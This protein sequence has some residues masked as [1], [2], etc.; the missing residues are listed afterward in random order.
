MEGEKVEK[1]TKVKGKGKG[2]QNK[3]KKQPKDAK[4]DAQ[5]TTNNNKAGGGG[6]DFKSSVGNDVSN[7]FHNMLIDTATGKTGISSPLTKL[8]T[9]ATA[10]IDIDVS[11]SIV[12]G[13]VGFLDAEKLKHVPLKHGLSLLRHLNS[14]SP[15]SKL[16]HTALIQ[17]FDDLV[18]VL[19]GWAMT[20]GLGEVRDDVMDTLQSL[21]PQ[22]GSK[23][24]IA[25]N[26]LQCL[27]EDIGVITEFKTEKEDGSAYFT[28]MS[29]PLACLGAISF[30][31]PSSIITQKKADSE[32]GKV[33]VSEGDLVLKALL[34]AR[35]CAETTSTHMDKWRETACSLVKVF[36]DALPVNE[37]LAHYPLFVTLLLGDCLLKGADNGDTLNVNSITNQR[38]QRHIL[39]QHASLFNKLPSHKLEGITL[40]ILKP[41][42]NPS[43]N[44]EL[45]EDMSSVYCVGGMRALTILCLL[46]GHI[47]GSQH[48]ISFWRRGERTY[49]SAAQTSASTL[50]V[51]SS[52]GQSELVTNKQSTK[53]SDDERDVLL[54]TFVGFAGTGA[55]S[56]MFA[57]EI[58]M[59]MASQDDGH[60][61]ELEVAY[62]N[63]AVLQQCFQRH[64]LSLDCS[65]IVLNIRCSAL[66]PTSSSVSTLLPGFV[67]LVISA[68]RHVVQL[69]DT[70]EMKP[71]T[72]I[73][74]EK[75]PQQLA[76]LGLHLV[77]EASEQVSEQ[78]SEELEQGLALV[79]TALSLGTNDVSMDWS[80]LIHVLVRLFSKSSVSSIRLIVTETLG[81]LA[82]RHLITGEH[83]MT[84][85]Q[86]VLRQQ[87]TVKGAHFDTLSMELVGLLSPCLLSQTS[88]KAVRSMGDSHRLQRKLLRWSGGVEH[89]IAVED[90]KKVLQ[91]LCLGS[92]DKESEG[93]FCFAEWCVSRFIAWSEVVDPSHTKAWTLVGAVQR[94]P[95]QA[96]LWMC[97]QAARMVV[98][99]RLKTHFGGPKETFNAIERALRPSSSSS[100]SSSTTA[101]VR[102]SSASVRPANRG[103]RTALSG[104]GLEGQVPRAL[105]QI[106]NTPPPPPASTAAASLPVEASRPPPVARDLLRDR[107]LLVLVDALEKHIYHASNGT[108]RI[109]H[110][111]LS[112][113]EEKNSDKSESDSDLD[114][115]ESARK[116]CERMKSR[117][118]HS[119]SGDSFV[120]PAPSPNCEA[121]FRNNKRVCEDWFARIRSLQMSLAAYSLSAP[122]VVRQAMLRLGDL[123]RRMGAI[124]S[125]SPPQTHKEG[126]TDKV[127]G[128]GN[129]LQKAWNDV[130]SL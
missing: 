102:P 7:L 41:V 70:T 104:R 99:S 35:E 19:L 20:E 63:I 59:A 26:M 78:V 10:T 92:Q 100:P 77:E 105:V 97:W 55:A 51:A 123:T 89:C 39:L 126:E 109:G 128:R 8:C 87:F 1:V 69:S 31:C 48:V 111:S 29:A 127:A 108:S 24:D 114:K 52:S 15:T 74:L 75:F 115:I 112:T 107:L 57:L 21:A 88:T 120:L 11:K 116:E 65:A 27:T 67:S 37:L 122:D 61:S 34:K 38:R 42:F 49:K 90:V 71:N 68:A 46:R 119:E 64:L 95:I 81:M 4:S 53:Q 110:R 47:M 94:N 36:T 98:K 80:Q 40:E 76:S 2:K 25:R 18:D 86:V 82:Q 83:A 12:K 32:G 17:Y 73:L 129:D 85:L 125:T 79:H 56:E 93:S 121:F 60:T 118:L 113:T 22:W 62:F 43:N 50:T 28:R 96:Q 23:V 101:P 13:L 124:C 6:G 84:I 106:R 58:S 54:E 117:A 3:E 130:E 45:V 14:T 33:E 66:E 44:D 72:S 103:G 5:L 9:L 16:H 91:Y 30:A